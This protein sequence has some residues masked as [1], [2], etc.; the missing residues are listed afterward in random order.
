LQ[1]IVC[2][3]PSKYKKEAQKLLSKLET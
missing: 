2:R 1:Y 3:A